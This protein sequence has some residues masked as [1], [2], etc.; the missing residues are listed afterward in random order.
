MRKRYKDDLSVKE[1][2]KLAV[3]IFR[4]ILEDNFD[5]GRVDA[6]I[7]REVDGKVGIEK[8]SGKKILG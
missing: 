1:G 4:E 5:V 2:L 3:D 6:G 8:R 7:L